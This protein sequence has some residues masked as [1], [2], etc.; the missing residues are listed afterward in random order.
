[1]LRQEMDGRLS[2]PETAA[3]YLMEESAVPEVQAHEAVTYLAA[4]KGAVG[5][6][7]TQGHL[8]IERFFDESGGM[9]LVIHVPY[10]G[11]INR[12]F[13][14]TLRKRFCRRFDFELQAG[15]D[16]NG[17]VLSLGPQQSFP[18]E[19][20]PR[21]IA[22][23]EAE[24]LLKQAVLAAPV[25]RVR[26][27]WNAVR[28]LSVL[29]QRGG[30]KVPP[31][32]QRFRADDLL[33][34]VFPAVAACAENL[35]P[36]DIPIPDHPL[37]RQTIHDALHEAMDSTGLVRLLQEIREGKVRI[38]CI[39]TREP[40]PFSYG[41]LNAQPYAFL[42]DAPLEERRARAV[43]TRRTL[44]VE[45]VH[46]LGKLDPDAI[47]KV[48]EEAWPL[49]RDADELHDGLLS[50]GLLPE[51]EG[52]EWERWFAELISLGR[53]IRAK[54]AEG[55][56]FWTAAERWPMVAAGRPEL[57]PDREV[58]L[59]P[60]IRQEW[61]AEESWVAMIRGR[62]DVVGPTTAGILSRD[63]GLSAPS[64]E[65][66]LMAL[67]VE[68]YVLRGRF[69]PDA[70][71]IEWCT[72]RLL[73]R[74]HRL[75]LDR[76][77][78]QMAPVPPETYVLFLLGWSHIRPGTQVQGREGLHALIE[79]LQGFEIPAVLWERVIFPARVDRYDP[80]WL[81]DLCLSGEVLWGR[82]RVGGSRGASRILPISFMLHEDFH[83]L[84]SGDSFAPEAGG[85]ADRVFA[86]LSQR[87]AL[88]HR[89]IISETGLLPTQV[90]ETLWELTAAGVVSGDGFEAIRA[91]TS[92]NR[93]KVEGLRRRMKR[94]GRP[95]SPLRSMGG[96]WWLLPPAV[97]TGGDL[98]RSD[99]SLE[100]WA[101]QLLERY[102]IFFRDLLARESAAP[103]WR[104]LLPIYRRLESRGEIRGGRFVSGV[105]GEQFALPEVVDLL[106]QAGREKL[107]DAIVLISTA[108]PA[109]LVGILTPD[110]RIPASASNTVA[111][112]N[113]RYVGHRAGGEVWVDPALD[114][115]R[116]VK[117]GRALRQR[118]V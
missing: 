45:S 39:D 115:E 10:G 97:R 46:D 1:M 40:S 37:I 16:D 27:R 55:R 96:R 2:D 110:A 15:A 30:K 85:D 29:R 8:L 67:E 114:E 118:T 34:A 50:M 117:V 58:R 21:M 13:G 59:P 31:P 75:T 43:A 63:L 68:G 18:L 95:A 24:S 28:S 81:D 6:I 116:T 103:A 51:E 56:A 92:P 19:D 65:S 33:V 86:A 47:A 62:M 66:A 49:V 82:L 79:G 91:L 17:L 25:F 3:R 104:D 38:T 100:F 106:R 77:R 112:Q 98:S 88:F 41:I 11:R 60:D 74:I 48:R 52:G 20:V 4:Q 107:D 5:M 102:G 89:E 94:R 36:G 57:V 61:T 32:L 101:R 80:R 76:L 14:L 9:Q 53:A 93:K 78:R 105:G 109:N 26:W 7:P 54:D 69:T 70:G 35:M 87:G 113:G 64:V 99:E 72:R 83:R 44:S 90:E 22:P 71:E 84:R 12:A 42:D 73:S 111:Y 23:E 108:D